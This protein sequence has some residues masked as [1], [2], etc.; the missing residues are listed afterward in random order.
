MCRGSPR[1][2]TPLT[3]ST[4]GPLECCPSTLHACSTPRLRTTANSLLWISCSSRGSPGRTTSSGTTQHVT[5]APERMMFVWS[6]AMGR[7]RLAGKRH[8]NSGNASG[9]LSSLA[10]IQWRFVVCPR[11]W[12]VC[13]HL[14]SRINPFTGRGSC[15]SLAISGGRVCEDRHAA[16]SKTSPEG[17]VLASHQELQPMV[18]QLQGHAC[19]C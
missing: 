11:C 16:A 8:P 9:T 17:A 10:P 14:L 1:S 2:S 15:N 19:D 13:T 4:T 3:T 7:G 12:R 18:L 6:M 5:Y